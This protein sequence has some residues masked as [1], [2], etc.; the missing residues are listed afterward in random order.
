MAN[1]DERKEATTAVR[2]PMAGICRKILVRE[3]D[4]L[5]GGQPI[6]TIDDS[7]L[8][9]DTAGAEA[10]LEAAEADLRN[11]QRGAAPEEVNQAEAEVSRYRLELE[12]ARKVL[13]TNEWLLK[14]EAIAR[15][16]VD[17]SRREVERVQQ[18]LEA[19]VTRRDDIKNRFGEPDRRRAAARLDAARARLAYLRA[20][21]A[22][23]VVLA[24]AP[25]TL[26]QFAVKD[27]T[28]VNAGDLLGHVADLSKLRVRAYVDEPELGRLTPDAEVIVQWDGRPGESWRASIVRIPSQ[29]V[30]RGTRSVGEVLCSL[31]DPSGVLLPNLNVDVAIRNPDRAPVA[32]L[33]RDAVFSDA[34]E[35]YVWVLRDGRAARVAI[36]T[37]KS[38]AR[39]VEILR[40]LKVGDEVV[41]AGSSPI[42]EGARLRIAQESQ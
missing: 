8:R 29:V 3:G 1:D 13:E 25:G 38:T 9:A 41:L 31:L 16:D 28:Y 14:R 6:L 21:L 20:S 12:N 26:Y 39:M 23:S 24:P 2:A 36:E 10:E 30:P 35:H 42:K 11:V 15:S 7:S 4:R 19:A 37:G 17:Q 18:L 22:G 33:V 27:G 5:N 34:K 40:G 32:A